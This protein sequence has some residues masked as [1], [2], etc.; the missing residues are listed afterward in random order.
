MLKVL[1]TFLLF[2]SFSSLKA[3]L[4]LYFWDARQTHGFSN[5][6]DAL[7]EILVERIIQHPV[8]VLDKPFTH[9]K[10]LLGM[11]SILN[12]AQDNDVVWGTGVNGKTPSN[13][14][15]FST[16]DVRAVRGPL[17]RKFLL[18]RGINCPEVY[19]DPTLLLPICFPELQKK[20]NPS[21]DYIIIPHFSDEHLFTG[22]PHM[23]SVKENW[24]EVVQKILD[25][26]FVISS[27]LSGVIVAE[28]FQIP[29][30]LVILDNATNTENLF[31]YEDYYQ[32]TGRFNFKHA[33]TIEDALLM[34]GEPLPE[35]DLEK[36]LRAFPL[37]LF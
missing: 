5:F 24:Y 33:T 26:K 28:A 9:Q 31:K 32:G 27:S 13:A 36:L 29:A 6:G 25:S 2:T 18:E 15:R 20:Q 19:G 7:S 21:N 35:C 8:T 37:E 30:R 1:L 23:V 17:T 3:E 12:Y 34:G 22:N 11:G 14:Y 4:P 16:L 10:K